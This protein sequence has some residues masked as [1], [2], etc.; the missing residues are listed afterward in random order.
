MRS[1]EAD[2][3]A[4]P[5]GPNG[6]P[7]GSDIAG[8]ARIAEEEDVAAKAGRTAVL[9]AEEPSKRF[10]LVGLGPAAS[11]TPTRCARPRPR[12]HGARARRR[13]DRLAA[14]RLAPARRAGACRRRRAPSRHL[15]PGTLEDGPTPEHAV[16]AARPRRR[17]RRALRE[18][19]ERAAK[20]ADGR[21]PR[22]RPA[23][24]GA[25]VLTPKKLAD[26]RSSSSRPSTS[27]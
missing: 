15:R 3:L 16:R 12:S 10:V 6:I 26:A 4:I 25:N 24:T 14:R 21:E 27:T 1:A 18:S 23:N 7:A 8:A 20:I 19:A 22:A 11:S 2:V 5:V 9:Y 17:R 13:H